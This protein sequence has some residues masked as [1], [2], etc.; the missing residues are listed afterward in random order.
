MGK[1]E[2][3]EDE[4]MGKWEDSVSSFSNFPIPPFSNFSIFH[5]DPLC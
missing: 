2:I 3:E 1:W 5:F 4:E